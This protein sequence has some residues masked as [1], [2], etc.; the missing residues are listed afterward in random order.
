MSDRRDDEPTSIEADAPE[1]D[2]I[3]QHQTVIDEDDANAY[4]SAL[5][6]D[7]A[8]ISIEADA[9]EADWIEQHH[10]VIDEDD[11]NAYPSALRADDADISIE[12]D[13]PEAD[14][15]EQHQPIVEA[16]D[17]ERLRSQ[18]LAGAVVDAGDLEQDW[19]TT[20]EAVGAANDQ[21]VPTRSASAG[22]RGC[23]VLAAIAH[24]LLRHGCGAARELERRRR[25]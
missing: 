5:R 2:W 23:N 8:D 22:A 7:D 6:A 20:D 10:T 18:D 13:T 25:S 24:F 1:A 16:A 14:W 9:P 3:E 19:T 21:E 12:P 17:E 15:I 11:A 4:P